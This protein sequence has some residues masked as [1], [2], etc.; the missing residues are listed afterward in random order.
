M[1]KVDYSSLLDPNIENTES[2]DQKSI[3]NQKIRFANDIFEFI[4]GEEFLNERA[5]F[6]RQKHILETYFNTKN[7]TGHRVFQELV[8]ISGM[9]SGKTRMAAW[10]GAYQIHK[11]IQALEEYGDFSDY[12]YHVHGIH[13]ARGQRLYIIVVASALDQAEA[14]VFSQI[15][16]LFDDTPWFRRYIS[17]LRDKKGYSADKHEIRFLN[18]I[19]LKAE[20]SNSS[21]QVG[22]TIHT[23]LFDEISRLDVSDSEISKKTQKRSAQ[24]IYQGLSKGTTTF[25]KDRNIVVVS[26]PFYEDDFGM[27]LLLQSGHMDVCESTR[28]VI[29]T[30]AKKYPHKVPSRAGFHSSTFEFNPS[31]IVEEDPFLMG[32]KISSPLSF[33]RDYMALPPAGINSYMDRPEKIDEALKEKLPMMEVADY[34]F[35]EQINADGNGAVAL[36]TYVGK[37]LIKVHINNL[38]RYF[39]CCDP[40]ARKDQ[41]ALVIGHGEWVEINDDKNTPTKR[42]KTIIDFAT[43]WKPDK[44]KKIHV[45]FHNVLSFIKELHKRMPIATLTFDQWSAD[46][47]IQSMQSAG[48]FTKQLPITFPMYEALR[49]KF[50][51]NLVELPGYNT[52]PDS[53]RLV[54]ELKKL[55]LVRGGE[56][57][58]PPNFTKDIADCVARVSWIID[59]SAPSIYGGVNKQEQE[60][61]VRSVAGNNVQQQEI[62]RKVFPVI[63]RNS[64]QGGG[65]GNFIFKGVSIR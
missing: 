40:A 31:I 35:D 14:T 61:F 32:V 42:L 55:Q 30:M 27:Q 37:N 41:F 53:E 9:R 4:L 24:V 49:I 29:E 65:A 48:I 57:N 51:N 59:E 47:F 12:Y 18:K 54:M 50:N 39:V 62:L 33:N 21:S 8:I 34:T 63:Q 16:G 17:G 25:A 1:R 36:Q 20:D 43:T 22:K 44:E 46:I 38:H 45:N 5:L 3:K 15:K 26:A 64:T 56:V 6:P 2:V 23:L 11:L 13:I 58:H 60:D 52:C 10:I 7:A 19:Y 28:D